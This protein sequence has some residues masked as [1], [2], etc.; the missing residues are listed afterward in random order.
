MPGPDIGAVVVVVPACNEAATVRRC[1]DSLRCAADLLPASIHLDIV[2]VA[3]GCAD[4]TAEIAHELG[5]TV[6]VNAVANVGLAR[7]SGCTWALRRHTGRWDRTWLA[8]TDADSVVPSDWLSAQIALADGG[9]DVVVGTVALEP[10]ESRRHQAWQKQY[11]A[12]A[13]RGSR[14]G[15]V[16]G[17]N[18]GLRADV[19]QAAGGFSPLPSGEDADR[20][21]R[22]STSGVPTV[23]ATHLPV[24]TSARHDPR[25]ADGVGDDLADSV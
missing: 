11:D 25:A 14:H 3:N 1:L 17:A 2:V 21:S 15:H 18:L 12:D 4:R 10:R 9:A 8:T 5:A 20:V 16:H 13:A 19:Y 22:L 24:T 6:L 23:W 7:S